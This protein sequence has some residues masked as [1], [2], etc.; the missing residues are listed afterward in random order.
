MVVDQYSHYSY[1][2]RKGYRRKISIALMPLETLQQHKS[3]V[4]QLRPSR[5]RKYLST[6]TLSDSKIDRRAKE[7]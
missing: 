5:R 3:L 6:L 4:D 7:E 1:N 2:E